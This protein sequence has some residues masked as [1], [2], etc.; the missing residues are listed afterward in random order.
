[1]PLPEDY[2]NP[3]VS[4]LGFSLLDCL[5]EQVLYLAVDGAKIVS[6]PGCQLLVELCGKPERQL[7]LFLLVCHMFLFL[8][9]LPGRRSHLLFRQAYRR[10]CFR[11]N[12]P[13]A[14][15]EATAVH[16]RL[17]VAITT[18]YHQKIGD[19]GSFALFV[20]LHH[21]FLVQLVKRLANHTHSSL[22]YERPRI[23]NGAGLLALQHGGGNFGRVGKAGDARLHNL[24]AGNSTF[25]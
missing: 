13:R 25:S 3:A 2:R 21:V 14:L 7:L 12:I 6:R 16:N 22:H 23:N 24:K 11:T 20:K 17:R 8:R 15:I 10:G 9:F 18:E 4:L 1:M 5:G 19:H